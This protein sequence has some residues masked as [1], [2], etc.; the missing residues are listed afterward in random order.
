MLALANLAFHTPATRPLPD[1]DN[2]P[3]TVI[4][5]STN[6]ALNV[7]RDPVTGAPKLVTAAHGF[8]TLERQNP[9]HPRSA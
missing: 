8:L 9:N 5:P 2:R 6:S 1:F 7:S 3:T 4:Q